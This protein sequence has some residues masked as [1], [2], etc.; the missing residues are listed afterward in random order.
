VQVFC[1]GIDADT[2]DFVQKRAVG[3]FVSISACRNGGLTCRNITI[4]AQI[5][6]YFFIKKSNE[7]PDRPAGESELHKGEAAA[8]CL[9]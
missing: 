4:Q 2:A 7:V 1:Q 6:R 9:I 3:F 5:K 8:L